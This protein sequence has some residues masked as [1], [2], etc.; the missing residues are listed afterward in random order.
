MTWLDRGSRKPGPACYGLGGDR[1]TLTDVNLL[2]GLIDAAGFADG[3]VSL[4][5]ARAEAVVEREATRR[6]APLTAAFAEH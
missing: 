4:D 5:R 3:E 2:M 6:A 1:A